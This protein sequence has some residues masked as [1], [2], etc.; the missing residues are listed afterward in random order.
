MLPPVDEIADIFCGQVIVGFC[1]S[2]TVTVKLHEEPP[3]TEQLTVVVPF[4]NVEPDAGV[5]VTVP[6][7]EVGVV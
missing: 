5:Q 3:L 6:Q 4:W 7:L 2:L 1:V